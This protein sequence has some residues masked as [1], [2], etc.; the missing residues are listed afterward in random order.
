MDARVVGAAWPFA[1]TV[2]SRPRIVDAQRAAADE[3]VRR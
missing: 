3:D 2:Q 1:E